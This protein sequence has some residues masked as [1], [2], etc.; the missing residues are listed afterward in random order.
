MDIL[1]KNCSIVDG[2]GQPPRQGSIHITGRRI[3]AILAGPVE[4]FTGQVIDCTGKTVTPGFIDG[5]S[6]NDW[7][8]L[9]DEQRL[10]FDPFILQ[11]I[12]TFVAG[13]CG[14]SVSGY[15]AHC[16]C[17]QDIGAGL[18][19]LDRESQGFHSTAQWFDA[20]DRKCHVNMA[21]LAGHGTA[22]IGAN[23]LKDTPLSLENRQKMLD[24]LDTALRGGA[25]GVSLGLQYEP[26]I[27]SPY[28]ELV[29]VARLCVKHDKVLAVHARAYSAVSPTY[30]SITRSHMLLAMDEMD[31][32]VRQT[33]V[34]LQY[35][36]LIFVGSRT[37]KDEKAALGIINRLR[38]DGYDV[39]FDI[40][41]LNYGPSIITVVLPDWYQAMS[42]AERRKKRNYLRLALTVQVATRLLGFGFGDI[43]VTY[44]G[45]GNDDYIGKTVAQIAKE[46]GLSGLDA[47][48]EVCERSDF[49]A[50]VLNGKYQND[51]LSSRLMQSEHVM[52][53]TDAWVERRGKQNGAIYGAFPMFIE[54][55]RAQ[56]WPIEKSIHRMTGYAAERFKLKNRGFIRE[57]YYADLNVIDLN[58]LQSRVDAELPPLGI[59]Y[60]FINGQLVAKDGQRV[61]EQRSAGMS[62]RS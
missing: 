50:T 6:H 17:T 36:H 11:G 61:E 26:G 57:D 21:S 31:R 2:S 18:F 27:Y 37:W 40:F 20:V 51:Q 24:E 3:K 54:K 60:T 53:M 8:A 4:Q 1:L 59:D 35:S 13:N 32:L 23:G 62:I 52:F 38:D 55:A 29:D 58:A 12:T 46:K 10:Y 5:H 47:Y 28:D 44:A 48:L 9:S 43:L 34:R 56:G 41:P 19:S 42:K 22:R 45:E 7:F 39:S 14:F 25:C 33:G 49:K 15:S 30:R 16:A